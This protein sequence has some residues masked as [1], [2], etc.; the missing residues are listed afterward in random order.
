MIFFDIRNTLIVIT[1]FLDVLLG[2]MIFLEN[3]RDP[4]NIS[5]GV[6][7]LLISHWSIW[8]LF[9]RILPF[10]IFAVFSGYWLYYAASFLPLSFL[11]M[12]MTFPPYNL[13]SRRWLFLFIIEESAILW[14]VGSPGAMIKDFFLLNGE[15]IIIWG[16]YYYLYALHFMVVFSAGYAILFKKLLYAKGV[17]KV[18]ILYVLLGTIIPAM[19]AMTTNLILPWFGYYN[20]YTWGGQVF[21]IILVLFSGYAIIK[22]HLFNVKIIATE[23]LT[24]SMWGFLLIR[25]LLSKTVQ[26]LI[27]D[28]GIFSLSMF[29]GILLIR[30][31]IKEVEQRERLE[32]LTKQLGEANEELKRLNQEEADFI[33]IASHQLRT[34]LTIIKGYVSMI[35]EGTFSK[36]PEKLKQPLEIVQSTAH[37]LIVI[38][39]DLL[40]LSRIEAGKMT[41]Q[42]ET[43]PITNL[44]ETAITA[45][46][47]VAETKK[48]TMPFANRLKENT[49]I[50]ADREKIGSTIMN[51][52][53]N[54]LKYSPQNSTVHVALDETAD[55]AGKRWVLFSVKDSGI[56]FEK[57][58]SLG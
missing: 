57:N 51:F 15:K 17:T 30:S 42:F 26:D 28:G 14:L 16:P 23:L 38:V 21:M 10:G 7:T 4:V 43:G 44:V 25:A 1:I 12:T 58:E 48:I 31:V 33:T 41:Y 49:V 20:V 5:F 3:R 56:G 8:A 55:A 29:I 35:R 39:N 34:P 27:T 53:D 40:S 37:Q 22:H 11:V 9:F 36:V 6:M 2:L 13:F 52:I 50:H 19:G 54:A 32:I 47:E 46:H 18:Q 24:F 45:F